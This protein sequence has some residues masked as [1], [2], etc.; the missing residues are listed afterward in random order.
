MAAPTLA[1]TTDIGAIAQKTPRPPFWQ[2]W[3]GKLA[4]H[5]ALMR[6][7]QWTKNLACF[8]GLF[9]SG[10]ALMPSAVSAS[11]GG[12]SAFCCAASFVYALNDILDRNRDKAHPLKMRRP[13]PSGRLTVAQAALTAFACLAGALA[14]SLLTSPAVCLL[15]CCYILLN[16]AYSLWLKHLALLDVMLISC[17]FILRILGGTEAITVPARSPPLRSNSPRF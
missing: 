4:A 13:I 2:M 16:I 10:K 5:L 8:A 12:F 1:H 14:I 9:F 17:G 7:H 6:P 3:G 11:I 15:V